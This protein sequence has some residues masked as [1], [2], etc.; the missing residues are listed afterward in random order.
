MRIIDDAGAKQALLDGAPYDVTVTV[1][2]V[3]GTAVVIDADHIAQNGIKINPSSVSGNKLELGTVIAATGDFEF[4]N[5]DGALDGIDFRG[6]ELY[7]EGSVDVNGTAAAFP[8]GYFIADT[9]KAAGSKINVQAFD[10]MIL[11]DKVALVDDSH[12]FFPTSAYMVV[13]TC[14]YWAGVPM[15]SIDPSILPNFDMPLPTAPTGAV[16]YRQLISWAAQMLG[17]CVKINNKGQ[18]QFCW[19]AAADWDANPDNRFEGGETEKEPV[20]ISGINVSQGGT[21]VYVAGTADY[22]IDIIDNPLLMSVANYQTATDNIW[23]AMSALSYYP[24]QFDIIHNVLAE[25]FDIVDLTEVDGTVKTVAVTDVVWDFSAKTTIQSKGAS[26]E[27][28]SYA[29]QDAFTPQQSGQLSDA[30]RLKIGRIESVDESVYFDLNS[31]EISTN[32]TTERVTGANSKASYET[33]LDFSEGALSLVLKKEG[34]EIGITT[35]GLNGLDITVDESQEISFEKPDGWDNWTIPA[36]AAWWITKKLWSS[37]ANMVNN[38]NNSITVTNKDTTQYFEQTNIASSLI[39]ILKAVTDFTSGDR[40]NLAAD[41]LEV[42]RLVYSGGDAPGVSKS[43]YKY[44]HASI[45]GTL[46]VLTGIKI[47][48]TVYSDQNAKAVATEE[49]VQNY[50]ASLLGDYIESTGTDGIWTW[51]KWHSGKAVCC[52]SYQFSVA[53]SDWA[54]LGSL[55]YAEGNTTFP[56]GFFTTLESVQKSIG[57]CSLNSLSCW[58]GHRYND[59]VSDVYFRV[60]RHDTLSGNNTIGIDIHAVGRWI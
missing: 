6:A 53:A 54:A 40:V 59:T 15:A 23:N 38:I 60:F 30:S 14:C 24:A 52:G 49:Y 11:L 37:S 50:L 19:Y 7:V 41:G 45:R 36:K 32:N 5:Y 25:P 1:T 31:G 46:A 29:P 18:L 3:G 4:F 21:S 35:I 10:R 28:Q 47:G 43:E 20:T 44:D 17:R 34:T 27:T 39:Q 26:E 13:V 57:V 8:I 42:Q 56:T 9:V 12:V 48:S 16:T 55:Y 33:L 2:P 22:T 58:I 51:E